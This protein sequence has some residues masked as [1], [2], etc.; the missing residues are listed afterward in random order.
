MQTG[1]QP[2]PPPV[3]QQVVDETGNALQERFFRF[4]CDYTPEGMAPEDETGH[5]LND[6]K[7]QV[8]GGGEGAVEHLGIPST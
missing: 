4:L 5:S 3:Y 7:Q 6:Y 1:G 8:E 2:P